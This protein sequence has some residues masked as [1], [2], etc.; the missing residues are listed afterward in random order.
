MF[1]V[2]FYFI[3][4]C[5]RQKYNCPFSCANAFKYFNSNK[6]KIQNYLGTDTYPGES[7][8]WP[9]MSFKHVFVHTFTKQRR[10]SFF[11]FA[12]ATDLLYYWFLG[13]Q[14]TFLTKWQYLF[15]LWLAC[16]AANAIEQQNENLILWNDHDFDQVKSKNEWTICHIILIIEEII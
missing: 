6:H 14:V 5:W 16:K 4:H 8:H 15:C 10:F 3:C 13:P 2:I 7:W 11:T 1:F 12:Q 9:S